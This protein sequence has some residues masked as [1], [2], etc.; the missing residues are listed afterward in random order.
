MQIQIQ[1]QW[2]LTITTTRGSD[3]TV[4]VS[5]VVAC[6]RLDKIEETLFGPRNIWSLLRGGRL[7]E[8]VG[9]EVPLLKFFRN[10]KY[11]CKY[12]HFKN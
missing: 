9:C 10:L 4:V 1:I 8:V 7:T 11:K 3:E 2:N 5:E 6:A 12:K